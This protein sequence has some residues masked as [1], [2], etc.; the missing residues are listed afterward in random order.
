MAK[1]GN[2]GG[3]GG[4]QHGKAGLG[5][6]ENGKA[7]KSKQIMWRVSSVLKHTGISSP[8]PQAEAVLA[9]TRWRGTAV[10]LVAEAHAKKQQVVVP[11]G[12]DR[13]TDGVRMF[14]KEM[15]PDVLFAEHRVVSRQQRVT[16]RIDLGAIVGGE[17]LVLDWKSGQPAP[18]HAIQTA[19][20]GDL[21]DRDDYLKS[22][23][24]T[25]SSSW[26]RAVIYLSGNGRYKFVV[27]REPRDRFLWRSALALVAWRY[28]NGLLKE[29]DPEHPE[30]TECPF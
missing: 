26:A 16:G 9:L 1:W 29:T 21:A 8:P 12:I 11:T 28:D 17:P 20:Y 2:A 6:A 13:Y 27:N 22:L 23:L 30:D 4:V 24:P 19:G 14:F 3:A 5:A 15:D 18:S 7:G 25:G 10:H